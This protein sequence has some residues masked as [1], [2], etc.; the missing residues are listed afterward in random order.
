MTFNLVC[1][2]HSYSDSFSFP[3]CRGGD[4]APRVRGGTAALLCQV[5][6]VLHQ[7]QRAQEEELRWLPTAAASAP[8]AGAR[9]ALPADRTAP[10]ATAPAAMALHGLL[11]QR[12]RGRGTDDA[13]Y[14][15]G[16][17]G[18]ASQGTCHGTRG[19]RAM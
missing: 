11:S 10:G 9:V 15:S 5:Q 6:H 16:A 19:P 18:D 8:T 12:L 7:S 13:G 2:V 1:L 4:H 17:P 3:P 14:A